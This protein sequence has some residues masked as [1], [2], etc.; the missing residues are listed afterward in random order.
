MFVILLDKIY[1]K[2]LALDIEQTIE[3]RYYT[4]TVLVAS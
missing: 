3:L 1:H 4:D 2:K